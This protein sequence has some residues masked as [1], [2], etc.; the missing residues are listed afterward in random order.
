MI[1]YLGASS[2]LGLYAAQIFIE[3]L[4]M[5]LLLYYKFILGYI[6][7]SILVSFVICYRYGPVTNPRSINLIRWTLQVVICLYIYIKAELANNL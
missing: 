4:N 2:M 5:I 3:N 7:F 6:I 1:G